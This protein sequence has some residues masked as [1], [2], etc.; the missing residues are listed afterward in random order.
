MF[1]YYDVSERDGDWYCTNC[2]GKRPRTIKN[3]PRRMDPKDAIEEGEKVIARLKK[4]ED[5]SWQKKID[6]LEEPAARFSDHFNVVQGED[7]KGNKMLYPI[8]KQEPAVPDL[9]AECPPM[10]KEKCHIKDPSRNDCIRCH[11]EPVEERVATLEK[12]IRD[13]INRTWGS[14]F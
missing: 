4:E 2:A 12:Q 3:L 10:F 8:P 13:V 9:H 11:L 14:L 6:S 7:E 5:E 1:R